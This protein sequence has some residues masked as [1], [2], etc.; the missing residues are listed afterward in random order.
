MSNRE[1]TSNVGEVS[2]D[3]AAIAKDAA[4]E[5]PRREQ[6]RNRHDDQIQMTTASSSATGHI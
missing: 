2:G 6:R 4:G 1:L 3:G 5:G